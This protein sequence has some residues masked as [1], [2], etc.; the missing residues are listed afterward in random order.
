MEVALW[1]A[2]KAGNCS[3]I[4]L[5]VGPAPTCPAAPSSGQPSRL[6]DAQPSTTAAYPLPSWDYGVGPGLGASA[7]AALSGSLFTGGY[8]RSGSSARGAYGGAYG[9]LLA[10]PLPGAL[11]ASVA[12][13]RL[14]SRQGSYQ[15]GP[16]E[17]PGPS[18]HPGT[19]GLSQPSTLAQT[20]PL[21]GPQGAPL[22][23][24]LHAHVFA[25][26]DFALAPASAATARWG[27]AQAADAGDGG[28]ELLVGAPGSC[29]AACGGGTAARPIA[30]ADRKS[31]VPA[32]LAACAHTLGDLAA[33]AVPCN[34]G[35]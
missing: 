24:D 7:A 31:G 5:G 30:C 26:A 20:L 1:A 28:H 15:G 34:V 32:P 27:A 10:A 21:A 3:R 16:D 12:V 4:C 18:S 29:S 25:L 9:G 23:R 11:S 14:H 35:R 8:G 22:S 33:L 6:A 19:H 2:V 17:A 13:A